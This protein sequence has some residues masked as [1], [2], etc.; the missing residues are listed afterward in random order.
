MVA[1]PNYESDASAEPHPPHGAPVRQHQLH[2]QSG[3]ALEFHST[4]VQLQYKNY[5]REYR[6][7][8]T[9]DGVVRPAGPRQL[10]PVDDEGD[11]AVLG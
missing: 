4:T 3:R 9:D 5:S 1:A 2:L 8:P 6:F 7:L 10:R 11:Q